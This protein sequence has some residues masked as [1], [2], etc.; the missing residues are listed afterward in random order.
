MQKLGYIRVGTEDLIQDVL[1]G[2]QISPKLHNKYEIV[3]QN[4][5][6][7]S[8]FKLEG[9]DQN[10]I[11]NF[12]PR[13]KNIL[14]INKLRKNIILTDSGL[15]SAS[16]EV[17]ELLSGADV[18]GHLLNGNIENLQNGLVATETCL[19]WTIIGKYKHISCKNI[20][21]VFLMFLLQICGFWKV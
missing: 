2:L 17:E 3:V 20:F 18:F 8:E 21:C 13:L 4:L 11:C 16:P 19:G 1:G 14:L 7:N 9:L 6:D 15:S 5:Q 10:K 12:I